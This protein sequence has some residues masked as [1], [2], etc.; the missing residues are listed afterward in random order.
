MLLATHCHM[1][2]RYVW[3]HSGPESRQQHDL[4]VCHKWDVL[5][6]YL[7]FRAQSDLPGAT[8]AIISTTAIT[9]R[10]INRQESI[11]RSYL[12]E[13]TISDNSVYRP[14]SNDGPGGLTQFELLMSGF[15]QCGRSLAT[16][17]GKH[18]RAISGVLDIL[19]LAFSGGKYGTT[20]SLAQR[21]PHSHPGPP[22][23]L[24][25]KVK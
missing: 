9:C 11:S 23:K 25:V 1:P 10:I 16:C 4:G 5:S 13:V 3:P 18:A 6:S 7:Q 19:W 24:T 8:K 22:G 17:A 14:K 12:R 21:Q 20:V 15:P 2:W